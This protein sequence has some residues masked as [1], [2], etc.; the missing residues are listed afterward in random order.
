MV[1]LPGSV[2][3]WLQKRNVATWSGSE[4]AP[5]VELKRSTGKSTLLGVNY[6]VL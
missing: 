4:Q 2:Y 1:K 3:L 5:S 6:K